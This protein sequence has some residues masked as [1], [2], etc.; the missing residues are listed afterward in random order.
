MRVDDS[1]LD[2]IAEIVGRTREHRSLYFGASP[3]ASIAL[4]L[5]AQARAA[6][7]GRDFVIPDDVKALAPAALRHRV[8]LQ[9]DAEIEGVTRRRLRGGDPARGAGAGHRR[10]LTP[11][12]R[13]PMPFIPTARLCL[14]A[15]LPL[16]SGWPWWREPTLLLPMLAADVRAGAG[17]RPGRAAWAGGR[18]SPSSASRPGCCRSGGPTRCACGCARGRAGRCG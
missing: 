4:L 13:R 15:L 12:D 7:E 18:W 3:R 16:G 5:G 6:I 11:T 9:P 10:R 8:G 2:Y 14:L 17:G 1:L